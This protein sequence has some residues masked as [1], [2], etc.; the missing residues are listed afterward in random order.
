[1]IPLRNRACS[2]RVSN[3]KKSH[4]FGAEVFSVEDAE[5][6]YCYFQWVYDKVKVIGQG[7]HDYVVGLLGEHVPKNKGHVVMLDRGFT[8][9]LPLRSLKASGLLATGTCQT[10]RKM[11]SKKEVLSLERDAERGVVKHKR[12]KI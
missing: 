3:P 4:K 5:T 1:M 9:P 7:L 6:F 8:G 12:L 2:V 11:F 10:N